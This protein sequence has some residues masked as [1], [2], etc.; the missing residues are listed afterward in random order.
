MNK[1]AKKL[2]I[3]KEIYVTSKEIVERTDYIDGKWVEG[4]PYKFAFIHP[5]QPNQ[6]IDAKR[7]KTQMDWAY[8]YY[9]EVRDDGVYEHSY[10]TQY[11]RPFNNGRTPVYTLA[12]YQPEI[13]PNEPLEGFEIFEVATR[14]STSNKYFRV[15]DPRGFV[16]EISAVSLLG[17]VLDGTISNGVI[18]NKCVW[19][20]NKNLV[21]VKD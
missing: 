13:C 15:K 10:V 7:K 5:H 4:D 20:S 2:S 9:N 11:N 8:G 3:P 6:K 14:Y 19:V 1:M 18:Q 21:V 12:K 16:T 17:I